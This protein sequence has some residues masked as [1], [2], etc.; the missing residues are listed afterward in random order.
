M[1]F[2]LVLRRCYIYT[3]CTERYTVAG[4]PVLTLIEVGECF[5]MQF[6]G[7]RGSCT[8]N[9]LKRKDLV[10]AVWRQVGLLLLEDGEGKYV[11][12]EHRDKRTSC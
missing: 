7:R 11:A 9:I 12:G 4:I 2:D 5:I 1:A 3:E 6:N 10:V 8:Q